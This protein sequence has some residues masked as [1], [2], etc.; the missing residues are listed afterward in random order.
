MPRIPTVSNPTG[1]AKTILDGVK[2]KIG[3]VPNLYAT[4]AQSPTV[5]GAYLAFNAALAKGRLT[6]KERE[7]IALAVAE[8]NAC[9]YCL[10]AHTAIGKGA[11]LSEA[12]I[13][14]ARDG[15]PTDPRSAGIVTFARALVKA[16][17]NVTDTDIAAAKAA[18]LDDGLL[19]E[20]LALTVMNIFTNYSNH[21]FDTDIDFPKVAPKKAA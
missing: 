3:M 6:A 20:V 19:V 10:S 21:L 8:T 1:D 18:G 15:K 7:Q 12:D 2:A 17:G 5:V 11:G 16:Q 13:A 4:M 14:L 9:G